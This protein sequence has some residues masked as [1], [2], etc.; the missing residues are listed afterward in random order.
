MAS[1]GSVH[2]LELWVRDIE[3]AADPWGW[4]LTALGYTRENTW[5]VGCSWRSGDAY[6]VLES[7]PDVLPGA[8]ERCR[9]GLNHLAFHAGTEREVEVLA[10]EAVRHG[11]TLLFADRHPHAGGP[12]Q[13][14]A[15]LENDDGFEVE[16]VASPT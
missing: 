15:Y 1:R 16:L 10:V 6:I 13:Y 12:D 4:L 2:H 11:W 14:A 8:H 7:G 9:P 5:P 3:A